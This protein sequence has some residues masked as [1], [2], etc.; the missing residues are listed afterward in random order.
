MNIISIDKTLESPQNG[1]AKIIFL[2]PNTLGSAIHSIIFTINKNKPS[3]I[4]VLSIKEKFSYELNPGE[5]LFMVVGENVDFMSATL[6]PNKTYYTLITPKIGWWKAKFL[7]K[8]IHAKELDT[9]QFKEWLNDC[10]L[11]NITEHNQTWANKNSSS[12]Q[13]KYNKYYKDWTEKETT[14]KAVLFIEDGK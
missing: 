11:V 13:S 7:L 10:Q 4:G 6:E 12:I 14:K 5:H 1:K 8:P 2:R 3:I 9:K